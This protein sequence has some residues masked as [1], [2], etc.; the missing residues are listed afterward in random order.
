LDDDWLTQFKVDGHSW[1]SVEHYYQGSKYKN[2][3]PDFYLQFSMDSGSEI[4]K[5]TD[6]ARDA[7]STTGKKKGVS[8][9]PKNVTIDANFYGERSKVV[10]E[11]ALK[12][13]FQQNEDFKQLLLNTNDAKLIHFVR[14]EKAEPDSIL[15]KVRKELRSST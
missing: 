5:S 13:K 15:M 6:L 1:A 4:S 14:G 2:G 9:R 8:L 10:R 12:A 11:E 7:T 3:F